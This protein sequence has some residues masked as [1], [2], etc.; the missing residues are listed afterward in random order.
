MVASLLKVDAHACDANRGR[1]ARLCVQISLDKPLLSS[2]SLGHHVQCIF[3]EGMHQIC[4]LC[5]KIGHKNTCTEFKI[6]PNLS[7]PPNPLDPTDEFTSISPDVSSKDQPSQN[8][9]PHSLP[10]YGPWM[11]ANRKKS[12]NRYA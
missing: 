10:T 6:I 3:Y 5:G 7:I 12:T 11:L 2:V 4:F 1:Y 9:N 8:S